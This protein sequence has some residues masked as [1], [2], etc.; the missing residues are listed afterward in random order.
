MNGRLQYVKGLKPH[1]NHPL[2]KLADSV[3][4][5]N[6][7]L[8]SVMK[9]LLFIVFGACTACALVRPQPAP[10]PA[11]PWEGA[12]VVAVQMPDS[13]AVALARVVR[14]LEQYGFHV[15]S[16]NPTAVETEPLPAENRRCS[17]SIQVQLV[18][19][20]ALLSGQNYCQVLFGTPRPLNYSARIQVPYSNYDCMAWGVAQLEAVAQALQGE[21][22]PHFRRP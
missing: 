2:N 3:N 10:A 20:T 4:R 5:A 17:A 1:P 16:V 12:N 19:H 15:R 6:Q 9:L 7:S 18:G 14:A 21:K 22:I 13:G 11:H 8:L